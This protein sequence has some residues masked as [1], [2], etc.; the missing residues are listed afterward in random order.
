MIL[1]DR[2]VHRLLVRVLSHRKNRRNIKA[3][4]FPV[5]DGI[6]GVQQFATPHHLFNRTESKFSHDLANLFGNEF[7]K[8]H[9]ELRLAT[10]ACSQNWVLGGNTNWA[11]VKVTCTHH[12]ATAHNKRS[13]RETKLFCS[14]KRCHN[15]VTSGLH[16]SIC[17]HN[18]AVA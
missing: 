15:D 8:V 6:F 12:D 10:K 14:E 5:I 16:L 3:L 9:D 13:R 1:G 2:V 11:S 7:K 18:N 4:G 17:L